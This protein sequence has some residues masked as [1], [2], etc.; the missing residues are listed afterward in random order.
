M[1]SKIE[2]L[3]NKLYTNL[4]SPSGLASFNDLY[5]YALQ[6]NPE[7]TKSMVEKFL[8]KQDSY[9]LYKQTPHKYP[10]RVM[11]F[12]RPGLTLVMDVM[13]LQPMYKKISHKYCLVALDGFSRYA[14]IILLKNLRAETVV[15]KLEEFLTDNI[16]RYEKV[17]S[18]SGVEFV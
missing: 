5:K 9:T 1:S 16:F 2:T 17:L 18:D 4:D 3:L 7:I 13:Y 10:R 14:S 6:K 8:R 15:P 12:R 11:Y